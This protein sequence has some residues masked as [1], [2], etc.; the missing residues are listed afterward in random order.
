[1]WRVSGQ[2]RTGVRGV[3]QYSAEVYT[4]QTSGDD[5]EDGEQIRQ[6]D[7]VDKI[8]FQ[9]FKILVTINREKY[10]VHLKHRCPPD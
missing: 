6:S 3:Y 8:Y 4:T 9:S 2:L 7:D 5:V 10:G 1:M